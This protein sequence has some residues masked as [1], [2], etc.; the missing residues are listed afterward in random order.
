MGERFILNIF[1]TFLKKRLYI[2]CNNSKK[3]KN[4]GTVP[5]LST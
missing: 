1:I 2:G 4:T 3:N 5:V